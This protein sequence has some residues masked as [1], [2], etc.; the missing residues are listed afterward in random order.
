LVFLFTFSSFASAYDLSQQ[1]K[2]FVENVVR[3]YSSKQAKFT[4]QI[5][6]NNYQKL[7]TMLSAIEKKSSNDPRNQ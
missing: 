5:Q 3:G 4:V 7:S 2:S 6:K 1:D